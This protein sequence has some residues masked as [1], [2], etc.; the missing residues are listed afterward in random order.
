MKNKRH[1]KMLAVIVVVLVA[2]ASLWFGP[3]AIICYAQEG[4]G[5]EA[6]GGGG[7]GIP[8][9]YILLS[10][11][12]DENGVANADITV[13]TSDE[14]C[15]LTINKGTQCLTRT[16]DRLVSMLMIQDTTPPNLP[17]DA[18]IV[19][20]V[21]DILPY[22]ATFNPPI[23]ITLT[24]DLNDIPE[25]VNEENLVIAYWDGSNWINLEGPFSIDVDNNTISAP[26][27]HLTNFTVIGST[28]PAAFSASSLTLSPTVIDPGQDV[29]IGVTITNTGDL[30]GSHEVILEID[31]EVI[32]STEVTLSGHASQIVTFS[33][34]A[35]YAVGDYEINVNGLSGILTIQEPITPTPTPKPTPTPTPTPTPVP[36]PTPTPAPPPT[37]APTPTLSPAPPVTTPAPPVT[38][39]PNW[40]LF[41][42]II[43]VVVIFA[44]VIIWY[45]AFRHRRG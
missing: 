21:Y 24:Y 15:Q 42:V 13:E 43:A 28:H 38:P 2:A 12:L 32:D 34:M 33:I 36:K 20:L 40:W 44:V 45:V 3:P 7:G 35:D 9:T 25:G 30:A 27:S 23:T 6:G 19:G 41:G 1:S 22:G 11:R 8:S 17:P 5:E 10:T 16:G 26:L 39:A 37:P 14:L 29:T 4:Y 31:D 18:S